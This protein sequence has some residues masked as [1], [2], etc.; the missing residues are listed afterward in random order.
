MKKLKASLLVILAVVAVAFTSC[1]PKEPATTPAPTLAELIKGKTYRL[2]NVLDGT[3]NVNARFSGFTIA[4]NAAGTGATL[5][6]NCDPTTGGS[7]TN[8]AV[9]YS[10]GTNT[11]TFTG[12]MP[13]GWPS[14]ISSVSAG[15]TGSTLN[16]NATIGLT[17]KPAIVY[18]FALVTP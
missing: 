5:N 9:T 13:S 11:I 2:G 3:T 8:T 18:A 10:A 17:G 1:K 12:T 6:C 16:F 14:S 7:F 4:F 15:T